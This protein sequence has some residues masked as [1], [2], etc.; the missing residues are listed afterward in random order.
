MDANDK[1]IV[2]N[3]QMKTHDNSKRWWILASNRDFKVKRLSTQWL[4][5]R[6]FKVKR[7]PKRVI[8]D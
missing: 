1:P 8:R 6:D 4:S 5:N 3:Y 2:A 7:K